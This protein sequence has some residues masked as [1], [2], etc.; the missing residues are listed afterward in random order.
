MKVREGKGYFWPFLFSYTPKE[1]NESKT[2]EPLCL[3]RLLY[4]LLISCSWWYL[5][6]FYG[7][8][9]AFILK[10]VIQKDTEASKLNVLS[11]LIPKFLIFS[12]VILV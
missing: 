9:I 12:L 8:V 11:V 3:I 5:N 10:P 6:V 4:L 7:T 1:P 2:N